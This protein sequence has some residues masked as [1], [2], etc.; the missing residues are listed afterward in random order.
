LNGGLRKACQKCHIEIVK[1]LIE[2]GADDL[3]EGLYYA[4]SKGHI[5]I[6]NFLIEKGADDLNEGLYNAC[7][8]GHIET[9]KFL[10]EKGATKCKIHG[11]N[12]VKCHSLVNNYKYK[13]L[14]GKEF[15]DLTKDLELVR[16]TNYE[17]SHNGYQFKTGENKDTMEFN[18]IGGCQPGGIYFIEKDNILR[19]KEYNNQTMHWSRKVTIPNNAR[20]YIE[21]NKFKT[22]IIILGERVKID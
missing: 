5:E 16:L 14:T 4:C 17:E 19:W 9:V 11:S 22:D 1:L 13:E 20:V 7:W 8:G 3:N 10:I 6:V 21:D 2:K 12:I 18:P 15:N